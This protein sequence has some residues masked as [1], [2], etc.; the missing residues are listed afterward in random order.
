M[1]ISFLGGGSDLP[2]YTSTGNVG[3]CV[4]ATIDRYSYAMAKRRRDGRVVVHY[5]EIENVA[6]IGDLKNNYV[7]AALE[8]VGWKGGIE[9]SLMADIGIRMGLGGSGSF[10]V[11]L[12]TAFY[13]L[14]GKGPLAPLNLAHLAFTLEAE[15]LA[16]QTG[17]QDHY[18]AAFGGCNRFDFLPSGETLQ[19]SI[20]SPHGWE[21]RLLLLNT[22]MEHQADLVFADME[23][24]EGNVHLYGIMADLARKGASYFKRG[25]TEKALG[26]IREAWIIKRGSS[27][28]ISNPQIE[29]MYDDVMNAGARGGKVCGTGGGGCMLFWCPGGKAGIL[30]RL[31]GKYSEVSFKFVDHGVQTLLEV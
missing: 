14:S 2:F 16:R 29:R 8:H 13:G 18:A 5:Q 25:Q 12:L 20:P 28:L 10:L 31:N 21:D 30:E 4:S 1:R 9:I 27:D 3:C 17:R 23:A 6:K 7:R 26:L 22:E 11:A 15:T 19:S 24:R